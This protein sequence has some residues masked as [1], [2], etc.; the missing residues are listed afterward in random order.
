MFL[1]L[2]CVRSSVFVHLCFPFLSHLLFPRNVVQH[3]KCPLGYDIVVAVGVVL[4]PLPVWVGVVLGRGM[5][6]VEGAS[7]DAVPD[8]A[9]GECDLKGKPVFRVADVENVSAVCS[10]GCGCVSFG[11]GQ[12]KQVVSACEKYEKESLPVFSSAA[13]ICS[14]ERPNSA[15]NFRCN[16][17][18]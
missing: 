7:R 12:M 15:Q 13:S 16:C 2:V 18:S 11:Y 9:G 4:H 3:T 14:F 10:A 1:D 8:H 5:I 17:I 6:L